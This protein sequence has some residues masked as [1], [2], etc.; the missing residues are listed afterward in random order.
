MSITFST[1]PSPITGF[2]FTCGHDNGRTE[3]R[4]GSYEDARVFLQGELDAHGYT[5]GLAVCGDV[6]CCSFGLMHIEAIESDPAPD[7]NVTNVNARHLL[8]LLGLDSESDEGGCLSGSVSAEDFLGRV[9]LAQAVS[10]SDAG[11]PARQET[12][13]GGVTI[14]H[15][16]RPVGY[17]ED[18]LA[19]LR[20]L[21]D[22]AINRRRTIQWC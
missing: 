3:H 8:E 9:L 6:D 20:E 11:I 17:S 18:R 1:E 13:L 16:G 15:M 21:A 22:F 14:V 4:F 19:A 5:G 7:L 2:A 10:P 12:G